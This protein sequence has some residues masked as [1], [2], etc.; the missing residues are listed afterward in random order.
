LGRALDS[1]VATA[2][3][4]MEV[5]RYSASCFGVIGGLPVRRDWIR[6]AT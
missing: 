5:P 4:M 2:E 1:P 6:D 3:M